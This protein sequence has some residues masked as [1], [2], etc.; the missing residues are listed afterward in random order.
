MRWLAG[1][2]VSG[3]LDPI[4]RAGELARQLSRKGQREEAQLLKEGCEHLVTVRRSY[5][6]LATAMALD[7][8][9]LF[10]Q[11]TIEGTPI[12]RLNLV[13]KGMLVAYASLDATDLER[14]IT[15]VLESLR[16]VSSEAPATPNN[17][18]VAVRQEDLDT[19][20]AVSRWF[21]EGV[22]AGGVV[23]PLADGHLQSLAKTR[24]DLAL[25]SQALLSR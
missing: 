20:L 9:Y 14:Q 23:M 18:L 21:Q 2:G 10:R 24:D 19:L 6:A 25:E 3:D 7:F 4:S 5:D 8:A 15:E 13:A 12:V 1:L 16:G 17:A 11:T 22:K